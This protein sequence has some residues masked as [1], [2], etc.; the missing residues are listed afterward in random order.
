[1][2]L[3]KIWFSI[4]LIGLIFYPLTSTIFKKFKDKGWMLSKVIGIALSSILMWLLSYIGILKYTTINSYIVILFFIILNLIILFIRLKKKY[5]ENG[6]LD[7]NLKN[8]FS[9]YLKYI[10][11]T[12]ILFTICFCAWAFVKGHNPEMKK[13]T[14]QFMDYGFMN[15]IMNSETMPPKDIWFSGEHINYYYFGQYVSGF[16]CKLAH[17][18]ASEGY[19]YII[20]FIFSCTFMIPFSIGYNLF[21]YKLK[22]KN[23]KIAIILPFIVATFIAIGTSLGGSLHYPIYRWISPDRGNYV[24]TQ[25]VRYIGAEEDSTDK[26]ATEVPAYSSSVSDLHAH[27]VDLIFSLTSLAILAQYFIEEKKQNRFKDARFYMQMFIIA[28]LLGIQ[29]MTN[30]WDFPIYIV[31][32]SAVVITK[33]LICGKFSKKNLIGTLLTIVGIILFE[34]LCTLPFTLDLV[35]NSTNVYFTGRCSPF[36]QLLVKWGIPALCVL[37]FFISFFIRFKKEKT[38]FKEYLNNHLSDLFIIILGICAIGLVFLPEVVYLKDIY[39]DKFRRFNT[40]FKLTYQA[41]ILFSI[42]TSYILY[43]L[44]LSKNKIIEYVSI[45]ILIVYTTTFGYGIDVVCRIFNT[46]KFKGISASSTEGYIAQQMPND[47]E[48]IKWI[49]ENIDKNSLIVE[50]TALGNSFSDYARISTFT[51]NSTVLGWSYHEWLWR[52]EA[53][54]SM[55][56]SISERTNDVSTLYTSNDINKTREII[57]KYNIDYIYIGDIE[58]KAYNNLNIQFLTSLGDIVYNKD[59]SYLIKVNK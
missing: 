25:E 28:I 22:E 17:L 38:K 16:V 21:N 50:A 8:I 55:P 33:E 39:G 51:G 12:E 48:A 27:Y 1:M 26:T 9:K 37:M 46:D 4:F 32:I 41:F 40:M 54:Y 36:Y 52:C 14:E 29:K 11:I 35:V 34:E 7:F 45:I 42:S 47:Y 23:K 53:D 30:F 13:Y 6:K 43:K 56:K 18:T 5:K 59:T 58:Y 44:M 31:I 20:C 49:R 24:Y 2:N 15:S 19:N 10:L 57:N 3:F